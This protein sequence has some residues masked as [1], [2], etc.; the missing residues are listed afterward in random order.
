MTPPHSPLPIHCEAARR[1]PPATAARRP[2]PDALAPAQPHHAG[3][4]QR[5]EHVPCRRRAEAP[6]GVRAARVV[7]EDGDSGVRSGGTAVAVAAGRSLLRCAAERSQPF[8]CAL[9]RGVRDGDEG[10]VRVL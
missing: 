3:H 5:V 1:L 2:V 7:D 6:C 9:L 10:R 8:F 4:T